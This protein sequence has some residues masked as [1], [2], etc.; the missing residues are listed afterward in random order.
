[1]GTNPLP[2]KTQPFPPPLSLPWETKR[3]NLSLTNTC[4]KGRRALHPHDEENL[5][6]K[7]AGQPE[8]RQPQ[9]VTLAR[10]LLEPFDLKRCDGEDGGRGD[11]A[12]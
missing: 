4:D 11:V 3:G 6:T 7:K 5:V 12:I 1:M 8:E 10:N 9:Q 2:K